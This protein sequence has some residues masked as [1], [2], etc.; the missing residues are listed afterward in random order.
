MKHYESF[1]IQET[2]HISD[3]QRS[4]KNKPNVAATDL[5]VAATG[6]NGGGKPRKKTTKR[7]RRPAHRQ[8]LFRLGGQRR[9]RGKHGS[10]VGALSGVI[11]LVSGATLVLTGMVLSILVGFYTSWMGLFISGIILLIFGCMTLGFHCK[12][13]NAIEDMR[14]MPIMSHHHQTTS[15]MSVSANVN[16]FGNTTINEQHYGAA[17]STHTASGLIWPVPT[18]SSM[19]S[20]SARASSIYTHHT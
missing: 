1:E 12:T 4:P 19:T 5:M 17:G 16:I 9:R 10:N 8:V 3:N 6:Q 20:S 13:S 11:L 14:P 7:P 2:V 15:S 18:A